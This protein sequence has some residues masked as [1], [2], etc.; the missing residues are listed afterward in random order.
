MDRV[1]DPIDELIG[2]A[3]TPRAARPDYRAKKHQGV[4][5]L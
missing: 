5:G 2:C 4:L 3:S 1:V